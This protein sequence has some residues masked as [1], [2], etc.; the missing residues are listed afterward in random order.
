MKN[1]PLK[2]NLGQF[3]TTN[4]DYILSGFEDLIKNTNILDP[5]AG[6]QDLLKWAKK[7]QSKSI[8][9]GFDIDQKLID[10]KEVFY[11]DSLQNIPSSDFILTNPPYL[12]K[13]KM[14]KQQ[15]SEID[16]QDYED[17]YLLAIKKI[18]DSNSK[19]GIII[20]PINFFSAENSNKLRVEFLNKY[21]ITKIN[22]FTE[23]VFDD[24]TYNV[25]AF[26]FI[27]KIINSNSNNQA[28]N[29]IF[30]PNQIQ[31]SFIVE[32]RFNYKIGGKELN[33]IGQSTKIK[34]IR[35][36]EKQLF[37]NQGKFEISTFYTNKKTEKIY[38]VNQELKNKINQ[39]IILLNC[40]DSNSSINGWIK[41]EDIRT[42][43]KD[44]LV[45][46]NT[47][48][49]IAY[50]ILPTNIKIQEQEVIIQ[51]FN[52]QLNDLRNKYSSLFLTNFRDNN[53]KRISFEFCYKLISKIIDETF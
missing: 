23:Q 13:N 42:F 41:A 48:R 8:I 17:L 22:Y 21:Q 40:I 35:L 7:Y 44:C 14:S 6:N 46:K 10:N 25:V 19:E 1:I 52:T 18:I 43:E 39:N 2:K 32:E 50:I 26:H 11:N 5:F 38:S 49:N 29:F 31:Q 4:V 15:K 37:D 47:S 24:T 53:R 16:M 3:F 36:T 33:K 28:L 9:K 20:I 27:K 12:G 30:Y 45:G 51:K 34:I